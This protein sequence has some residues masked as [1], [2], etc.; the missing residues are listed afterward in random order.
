[1]IANTP[2]KSQIAI[3]FAYW[4]RTEHPNISVFW[5]HGSSVD[6][7]SEAFLK[8]SQE[9]KIP[10]AEDPK[11]NKLLLVRNWLEG[12][13]CGKWLMIIDNA[14]DASMFFASSNNTHPQPEAD[15]RS[16]KTSALSDYIPE[17]S[18]GSILITTRDKG[19]GNK[20]VRSRSKGLIEVKEMSKTES[21]ELI[22]SKLSKEVCLTP[23]VE[24]LTKLLEHLPLA[25]AQAAAFIQENSLT[26]DEYLEL[27]NAGDETKIELLSEPF[28]TMGRDSGVPNAVTATLVISLN[29]I[30]ERNPRAAELLSLMT[31]LDRQEIPKRFLQR[32]DERPLDLSKAL[33]TLKAFS[34]VV[35][36]KVGNAFD[37][38]RLV[39]LV[40]SKWLTVQDESQNWAAKAL[41]TVSALYPNGNFEH[42]KTC[43]A[44]LPHAQAVLRY[45]S[46]L[47]TEIILT[48]STLLS[49]V[50]WYLRS[51]GR[52]KEAEELFVQ[53][54]ETRKR[55]LGQEHPDTLMSM[56][57]LA[58]TYGNQGRW[59]EAEELFVQV[60]ETR[61][62]VLG[63][64]HSNTLISMANLAATYG[65]QGRWKEAEEL[66]VQV[67][68]T[69]KRVLGQEHPDTLISMANL[70]VT[71]GNQGRWKEAEEL[72][73]QMMETRKRVLG[74]EHPD[75]LISIANLAV[76]YGNQG[77][78]KEAEELEVQVMETS[79]RVLGQE[80][81]DTL[82]SMANLAA[83][84]RN[85]GRWKEAE[86]LEVQ[87]M[88]TRKKV[89]GREHP[90]TLSGMAN[91]ASTLWNQ[92]RWKE[93]E[94]LFVQVMETRK[95]M[96]G[97]EHPDTL[98]SMANLA[99]TYR[100]QGRWKEAEE[101]EVQ[102]METSLRVLGQEHPNT[103]TS[104]ANLAA[105][106]RNQGRWKEAEEL[107]VQVMETRKKVL[108]REHPNTLSGMANLA[109]T[110]WNQG[111]WK[112]AEELFVQVMET[113][114]R[115]LGQE[116]PDTLTSMANLAHTWKSQ[117]RDGE[118]I[119]L[120]KRAEELQKQVLGFD[121][122]LT[123]GSTQTLYK[124]QT[125]SAL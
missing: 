102:V 99:A 3:K 89:L 53:V 16:A 7:F 34:L 69:R 49:N 52:W 77:R 21:R 14:D 58:V 25:L 108:G 110:L 107:E 59:K 39:Q 100:N 41:E 95:R 91:L 15:A 61:K 88:E 13:E 57:N 54:M 125:L 76:T 6:R 78:W 90:F 4:I 43:A 35:E 17:C 111:R 26:I 24:A 23:G 73:V 113:S 103:L 31:F 98:I 10:G 62:R 120:L 93:A 60:M 106:Y 101:L 97:Q 115:V 79:L 30:R 29:Q 42:W 65:N 94:E 50:A 75:T 114:L 80:H 48:R 70:A 83:T 56:A 87:V 92:G 81:P 86:E 71:Y 119:E 112:E 19:A 32:Q 118:A 1:M 11:A 67:I 121:H 72:E 2:R 74:Q 40:L 105:T 51:Q 124:W 33:G 117:G 38:H 12:N 84:Y 104:M 9:F 63:Q 68:E 20:F 22:E 18:H 96:L 28:E 85:Q 64:E 44:Y 27:Y 82:M 109:S 122:Y 47:K 46:E 45:S 5:V 66:E 55:V 8:L 36:S 123:V 37:V 116:H